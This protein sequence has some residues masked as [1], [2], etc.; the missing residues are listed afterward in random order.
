MAKVKCPVLFIHGD[1]DPLIHMSHSMT[2]KDHLPEEKTYLYIMK[3]RTHI[4]YDRREDIAVPIMEAFERFKI[5]LDA[6]SFHGD[7]FEK[8]HFH[9]KEKHEDN[10]PKLVLIL[11]FLVQV[12][13]AVGSFT[14]DLDSEA[15][16]LG[17]VTAIGALIDF[18]ALIVGYLFK[19]SRALLV[20]YIWQWLEILLLFF[21]Q[22][23]YIGDPYIMVCIW[24]LIIFGMW[25]PDLVLHR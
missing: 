5:E 17:I 9:P 24:G 21:I 7:L 12:S 20:A 6:T 16:A 22:F 14:G 2:L 23:A 15:Y 1:K 3:D 10:C 4:N 19:K 13:F 11:R 8:I 25:L 18:Q